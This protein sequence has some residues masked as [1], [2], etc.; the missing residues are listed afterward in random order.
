MKNYPPFDM[1][2]PKKG[3]GAYPKPKPVYGTGKKAVNNVTSG[4]GSKRRGQKYILKYDPNVEKPFHAYGR[5]KKT[6]RVYISDGTAKKFGY[7]S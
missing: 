6:K 5:G 4:P 1:S 2:G 7:P 3:K